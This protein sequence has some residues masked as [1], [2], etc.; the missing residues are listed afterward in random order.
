[1]KYSIII[2]TLISLLV[3]GCTPGKK[4]LSNSGQQIVNP[5]EKPNDIIKER[6][7]DVSEHHF[8]GDLRYSKIVNG[9]IFFDDNN[10]C[11]YKLSKLDKADE[12]TE[13]IIRFKHLIN[14][15]RQVDIYNCESNVR[16]D[17]LEKK[18]K[19]I[20]YT[21]EGKYIECGVAV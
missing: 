4:I 17:Y 18:H 19:H 16:E 7:A 5:G 14:F 1:M 21:A 10:Y 12:F 11:S 3:S 6:P 15:S 13:K 9:K 8:C 2:I 20:Y